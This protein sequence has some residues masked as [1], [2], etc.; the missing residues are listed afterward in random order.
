MGFCCLL[1][2]R[3]HERN[4]ES[5][6][7]R[8]GNSLDYSCSYS[9]SAVGRIWVMWKKNRFSFS[10]REMDEQFVTG[11]LTDLLSGVCMEVFCVYASN[12]NIE[13]RLLWHWL[14]E[15]TSG[16]SSPGVVMGDF[17]AIRGHSEAFGGSPIQV[18]MEDFDLAIRDVDLVEPSVQGNWFTWTSKVHESG[19]LRRLDRILVNDE[20]LSAWPTLLFFNHWMEDPSFIEVVSRLWGRHEGVSPLASLMRNLQRLKPTLCRQIS[21]TGLDMKLT[22]RAALG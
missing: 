5:V 3:V 1:E 12:S 4:F 10:T 15:I 21:V 14:V 11:T 7:R 22:Q 19:V 2:T 17:N 13:R 18:E 8:F 16:W 9:N 6:S 20:W